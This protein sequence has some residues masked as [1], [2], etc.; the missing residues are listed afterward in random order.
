M[1][2]GRSNI[3]GKPLATLL[4]L[5]REGSNATVTVTHTRTA[6]LPEITAKPIFW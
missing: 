6:N 5:R 4:M 2:C 3:V 1:I